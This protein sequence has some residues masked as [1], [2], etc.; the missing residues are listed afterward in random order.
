MTEWTLTGRKRGEPYQESHPSL[1][2]AL[3]VI[4]AIHEG[5]A[6]NPI[7]DEGYLTPWWPYGMVCPDGTVLEE[8]HLNR[9]TFDRR[10]GRDAWEG[11]LTSRR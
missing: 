1:D 5:M 3:D 10:H 8:H 7:R 11:L 6:P 9:L 2:A 4:E